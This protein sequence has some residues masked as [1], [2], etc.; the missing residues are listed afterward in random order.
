MFAPKMM[1]QSSYLHAQVMRQT[2]RQTV[3]PP[4]RPLSHLISPPPFR[5]LSSLLPLPS[6]S[7]STASFSTANFSTASF[8]TAAVPAPPAAATKKHMVVSHGAAYEESMSG[9]HGEHL[10]LLENEKDPVL[11]GSPL[12]SEFAVLELSG[13]QFKVCVGDVLTTEKLKP[14]SKYFVG[15]EI[16]MTDNIVLCGSKEHTL[17]GMPHVANAS[18]KVRIE[19]ITRDATVVVFKKRRR[20]NSRTKNGHRREVTMLRVLDINFEV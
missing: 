4:T 15:A 14:V 6:H 2:M 5:P 19:E 1:R 9:K 16:D 7:F 20:K 3:R 12:A 13:S 11:A 8:S 18:V 10:Q 17:V